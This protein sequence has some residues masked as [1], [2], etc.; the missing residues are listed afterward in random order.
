[1]EIKDHLRL[2]RL[3]IVDEAV[4]KIEEIL[5]NGGEPNLPI[6]LKELKDF[7][8]YAQHFWGMV[9]IKTKNE[10]VAK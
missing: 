5:K 2:K 1:M 6:I 3:M 7:D 9:W 8:E 4:S 10:Y